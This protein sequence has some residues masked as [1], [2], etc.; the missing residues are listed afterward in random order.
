MNIYIDCEWNS[1]GGDL[2]SMALVSE[3][4][5]EFYEV[6]E[7][8]NPHPW[9]AENVMPVLMKE[10]IPLF[11]FKWLLK[12][13]LSKFDSI[14]IVADWPED[15]EKFCSVLIT[16]PGERLPSPPLSM[17]ILRIDADSSLPHNALEDARGIRLAAMSID[18]NNKAKS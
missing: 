8:A 3:N 18:K 7:C 11:R 13:Y 17:Q 10:F 4:N 5:L 2:I 15:I 16:S 12:D 6:L 14:N 1:F 9:V